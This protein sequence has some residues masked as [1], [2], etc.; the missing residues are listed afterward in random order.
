L[1]KTTLSGATEGLLRRGSPVIAV[2][3][4]ERGVVVSGPDDYGVFNVGWENGD[5]D[6]SAMCGS[7]RLDLKGPTG[8]AHAVWW[9]LGHPDYDGLARDC[10]TLDSGE[11]PEDET[12]A[13][14]DLVQSLN[15]AVR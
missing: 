10:L 9:V 8:R 2:W 11:F 14:Q 15:G 5:P 7:L 4:H 3:D 1:K 13:L 12:L 6:Q